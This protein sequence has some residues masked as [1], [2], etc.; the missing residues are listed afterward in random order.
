MKVV[1]IVSMVH[2]LIREKFVCGC[3]GLNGLLWYVEP[4]QLVIDALVM[5]N[6]LPW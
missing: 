3:A 1:V 2:L 6:L 5:M 4:K